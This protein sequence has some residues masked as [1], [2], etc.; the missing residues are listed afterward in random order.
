[1]FADSSRGLVVVTTVTSWNEPPRIRHQVT[2]QL[3][4]FYNVL[5]VELFPR[6]RGS[7]A[8][9]QIS[10]KLIVTQAGR[11]VRG[12]QRLYLLIPS[13]ERIAKKLVANNIENTIRK[14]GYE[15]A[16]LV[17][18]QFDF[19]EVHSL[20]IFRKKVFFC[21]DD[22]V[23]MDA[24]ASNRKRGH[25]RRRQ[26]QVI[27]RSDAVVA[28][29]GPLVNILNEDG[30]NALLMLPGHEFPA[31]DDAALKKCSD[32][33]TIAVCYMGYIDS[34][35]R[36]DWIE[37]LTNNSDIIF[38]F[39]GPIINEAL[40]ANLRAKPN[41]NFVP[42]KEGVELFDLLINQDVLVMPYDS[43]VVFKS[44][45]PNKLYQYIACGKPVVSSAFPNLLRMDNGFI[46]LATHSRDFME[47]IRIAVN[48]DSYE[49]KV[50]RIDFAARNTWDI[51]GN[52]I[53]SHV[54]E[55]LN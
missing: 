14:L 53:H 34:R 2:R 32:K 44:N 13:F 26:K 8:N 3:C 23:W 47:K 24:N 27:D 4:R 22:F 49:F 39:I 17:N 45:A 11:Y 37:D 7:C 18:F 20:P 52:W 30:A 55:T 19:P 48:E 28:V 36:F 46:Y 25:L 31:L 12:M 5:Y 50:S 16:K 6:A 33:S 29:S 43:S 42:S 21:N 54:L 15:S 10:E 38:T 51:R 35:L 9:R 41:V 40:V 1:M